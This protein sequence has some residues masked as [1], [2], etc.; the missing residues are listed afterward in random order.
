MAKES[1]VSFDDISRVASEML[2]NGIMPTVRTVINQT[3]GKTSSV[4]QFLK[5][6]FAKREMEINSVANEIG[7]TN[8]G[9]ILA[10][11]VQSLVHKK[12]E[13]LQQSKTSTETLLEESIGLLKDNERELEL[14]KAKTDKELEEIKEDAINKISLANLKVAKAEKLQA[15]HEK[16]M[17]ELQESLKSSIKVAEQKASALIESADKRTLQ[18]EQET[19]TLRLQVKDLS[20]DEATRKIERTQYEKMEKALNAIILEKSDQNSVI[21]RLETEKEYL[22]KDISRLDQKNP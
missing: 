15:S 4:S 18:A 12:T 2:L 17:S 22:M 19:A 13:E 8:M 3:G 6:F 14:F 10:A 5:D 21:V 11:E 7:S 9:K 20:I 1:S 16:T